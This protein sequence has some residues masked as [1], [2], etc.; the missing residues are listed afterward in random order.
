MLSS[1][2][3]PAFAVA[4]SLTVASASA[5]AEIQVSGSGARGTVSQS[6][7]LQGTAALLGSFDMS[8]GWGNDHHIRNIAVQPEESTGR[9]VVSYEDKNGDDSY[10]YRAGFQPISAAGVIM[11]EVTG[12]CRGQCTNTIPVTTDRLFVLRGFRVTYS[13]SDHCITEL[14]VLHDGFRT[15]SVALHDK[16]SDDLFTYRIQ[17]ALVPLTAVERNGVA[18]G[19]GVG[20]ATSMIVPGKTA[21]S[22]FQLRYTSSDHNISQIKVKPNADKLLVNFN[23]KNGDDGFAYFIKWTN[24]R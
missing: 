10:A 22:G 21:I 5:T 11:G 17:Y 14:K 18:Q 20:A 19:S 23:D 1:K 15:L 6:L 8:F 9:V 3:L 4:A 16:N 2:F 24:M 7:P 12:S 13:D